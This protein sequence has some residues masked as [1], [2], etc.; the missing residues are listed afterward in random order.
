LSDEFGMP[1]PPRGNGGRVSPLRT[2]L[3]FEP[4]RARG[5]GCTTH[6]S[7]SLPADIPIRAAFY[8][9]AFVKP[10]P[11]TFVTLRQ[12]CPDY[13]HVLS[14]APLAPVRRAP[15]SVNCVSQSLPCPQLR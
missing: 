8:D 1:L 3:L 6:S 13:G 14:R 10:H 7:S 2:H 9:A 15:L 12:D 11:L 5:L 4:L